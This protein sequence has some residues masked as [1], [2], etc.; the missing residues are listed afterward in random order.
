VLR[1]LPTVAEIA[2]RM[3]KPE[4]SCHSCEFFQEQS[5][6]PDF[7]RCHLSA[8]RLVIVDRDETGEYAET[9]WPKVLADDFCGQWERNSFDIPS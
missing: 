8:P 1:K 6:D 4:R 2:A 7:G 9:K 3:G 5:K